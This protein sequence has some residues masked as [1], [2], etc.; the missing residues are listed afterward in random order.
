MQQNLTYLF[1]SVYLKK[2][3]SSF[4]IMVMRHSAAS[5]LQ[6][7][8]GFQRYSCDIDDCSSFPNPN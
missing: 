4:L 3:L 8:A 1:L 5:S 7:A 6:A 2:R